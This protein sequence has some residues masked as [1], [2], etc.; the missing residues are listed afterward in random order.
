MLQRSL[1][2]HGLCHLSHYFCVVHRR[3]CAE[4]AGVP[5]EFSARQHSHTPRDLLQPDSR[6]VGRGYFCKFELAPESRHSR[7]FVVRKW[8]FWPSCRRP[9]TGSPVPTTSGEDAKCWSQVLAK[10]CSL[11]D[12]LGWTLPTPEDLHEAAYGTDHLSDC[13]GWVDGK[14]PDRIPHQGPTIRED[15]DG[16]VYARRLSTLRMTVFERRRRDRP[17]RIFGGWRFHHPKVANPPRPRA[18]PVGERCHTLQKD[19]GLILVVGNL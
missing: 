19:P 1:A 7:E 5:C 18:S 17:W 2:D 13:W 8:P 9:R 14:E 15:S 6:A 10:S 16:K 12:L 11:D 3:C 4:M